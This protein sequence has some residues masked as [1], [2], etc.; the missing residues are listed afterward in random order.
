MSHLAPAVLLIEGP[1]SIIITFGSQHIK[2]RSSGFSR[3]GTVCN[4][5]V[6]WCDEFCSSLIALSCPLV[7]PAPDELARMLLIGV[8]IVS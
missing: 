5:F 1:C 4:A 6:T 3:I 7:H 2:R 8:A